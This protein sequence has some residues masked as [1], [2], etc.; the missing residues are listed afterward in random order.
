MWI[1]LNSSTFN[2]FNQALTLMLMLKLITR[3]R[4]VISRLTKKWR[5]RGRIMKAPRTIKEVSALGIERG[6]VIRVDFSGVS[7]VGKITWLLVQV[8]GEGWGENSAHQHQYENL[9]QVVEMI[10]YYRGMKSFKKFRIKDFL[11][12]VQ[13]SFPYQERFDRDYDVLLKD[14]E[15]ATPEEIYFLYEEIF[16]H[17]KEITEEVLKKEMASL[18]DLSK[19]KE[20][21][22]REM[23][24]LNE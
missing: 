6:S 8:K 9:Q 5:E 12:F 22:H 24:K 11:V 17:I 3:R 19:S 18:R 7:R 20:R 21:M 1:E 23:V 15:I 2:F 13:V 4:F 14:I 16:L 10:Q